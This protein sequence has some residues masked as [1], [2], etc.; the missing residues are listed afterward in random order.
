MQK[1]LELKDNIFYK[2]FCRKCNKIP[3]IK[4]NSDYTLN[5]SCGD[6]EYINMDPEYFKKKYIEEKNKDIKYDERIKIED[7]CICDEHLKA[8]AY[9]CDDC[10]M[11]L[12]SE[13]Y[14]N[15]S[16]HVLHSKIDFNGN[17]IKAKINEII[18]KINPAHNINLSDLN[19]VENNNPFT[20]RY[21]KFSLIIGIILKIY[22]EYPCYNLYECIN[23]IYNFLRDNNNNN[24][25]NNNDNINNNN[26]IIIRKEYQQK[27]YK[28]LYLRDLIKILK[29][30]ENEK[31]IKTIRINKKNFNNIEI[32]SNKNLKNLIK[33]G[34][35]NNNIVDL[36]PFLNL[37]L[38]SLEELNLSINK[39]D[40]DNI[41]KLFKSY[42]PNL[43]FLNLY[44]NNLTKFDIFG[45]IHIFENL[46]K[47][48]IGLNKLNKYKSKIDDNTIY[49]CSKIE[50]I[51]LT[52]GIFSDESIDLITHFDFSNLKILYLSCNN[53]SNEK[54]LSFIEKLN[55]KNLEE[56]WFYSNKIENYFPLTKY[57]KLKK[58]N[59]KGNK[60]S[61]IDNLLDFIS[62]FED[63]DS[64]NLLDNKIDR[65]NKNNEEILKKVK[66]IKKSTIF[67]NS[68]KIQN[69]SLNKSDVK[70]E[71]EIIKIEI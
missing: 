34:L 16:K 47:F 29:D 27:Y 36:S 6:M 33:L 57:T 31:L 35:S 66:E 5:I 12:C 58:I 70:T 23:D 11:N 32:L 46:T 55:C 43:S 71:D 13:C 62:Y 56:F 51:G 9:F 53:I 40:D 67:K 20:Q 37:K 26:R 41:N 14:I 4:F 69:K 17:E 10:D 24:L 52:K 30:K 1:S 54:F 49:N 59:L 3:L 50:E 68:K 63:L 39:I 65:N 28:I 22:E 48:Y 60:I 18:L 44:F 25:N 21:Y 7:Y 64:I 61:K 38:P 8:F 42:I 2:I 15:S 19:V 45:K